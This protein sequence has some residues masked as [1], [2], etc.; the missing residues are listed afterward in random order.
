MADSGPIDRLL[1]AG[2]GD[3]DGDGDG[4]DEWRFS[5]AEVGPDDGAG[6]DGPRPPEREPIEPEPVSP[7]HAAFV[8]AG[9]A[10]TV[11]VVVGAVYL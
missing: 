10:L 7:E 8:L 5:V 3:S 9:A 11:L 2:G 6:E 4:D 1:G